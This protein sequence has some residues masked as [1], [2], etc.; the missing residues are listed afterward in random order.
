MSRPLDSARSRSAPAAPV[1]HVHIGRM[2]IEA[3]ALDGAAGPPGAVGAAAQRD[4]ETRLHSALTSL[5]HGAKTT[6][7]PVGRG[8]AHE[9]WVNTLAAD[10]VSRVRPLLPEA[11]P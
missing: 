11:N 4:I 5:L 6:L 10:I 3:G 7:P 1:I 2:V 8:V 9:R